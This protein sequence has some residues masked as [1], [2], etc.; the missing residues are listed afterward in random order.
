MKKSIILALTDEDLIGL[1]R[2]ILD[3]DKEEVFR[4]LQE[5]LKDK[6]R[7]IQEG[8]GHCKPWFETMG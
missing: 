1:Q 6:A 3:Q 2:I 8:E 4:F 7:A 5:H